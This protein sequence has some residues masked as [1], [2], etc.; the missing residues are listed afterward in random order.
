LLVGGG[1]AAGLLVGHRS[2]PTSDTVIDTPSMLADK[3]SS[4]VDAFTTPTYSTLGSSTSSPAESFGTVLQHTISSVL[5]TLATSTAQTS[6]TKT[7]PIPLATSSPSASSPI[8]PSTAPPPP[9]PAPPIP[10]SSLMTGQATIHRTGGPHVSTH[11]ADSPPTR[12]L[13]RSQSNAAV[14]ASVD[15][16]A[17]TLPVGKYW[18]QNVA[19]TQVSPS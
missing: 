10:A 1:L 14:Q 18:I 7:P 3:S 2:S 19:T 6:S 12:V 11:Q 17:A 8:H 5:G 9:P 4:M 13:I 16:T 15:S